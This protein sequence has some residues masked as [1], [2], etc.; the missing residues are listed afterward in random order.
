V[1]RRRGEMY[2]GHD[3][4]CVCLSLAACPHCTD[5][6]VSWGMV[7]GALYSCA[8]L[9]DLQSVHGFRCYG[10][11][12]PNAKCQPVLVLALYAWLDMVRIVRFCHLLY[13]RINI[14]EINLRL[15]SILCST[16]AHNQPLLS[17]HCMDYS[18]NMGAKQKTLHASHQRR[19]IALVVY[20]GTMRQTN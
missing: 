5:P 14:S 13:F 11:T 18:E 12:A 15:E 1:R 4:L 9:T 19:H 20:I 7:R 17:T 16:V 2:T 8:L 3:R 6:D 10:N